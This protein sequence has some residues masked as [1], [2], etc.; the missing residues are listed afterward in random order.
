MKDSGR[1]VGLPHPWQ[2]V[3]P[4]FPGAF[5]GEVCPRGSAAY[6]KPL[7]HK[8]QADTGRRPGQGTGYLL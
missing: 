6:M 8:M 2:G 4:W 1:R 5:Y 3:G 7:P